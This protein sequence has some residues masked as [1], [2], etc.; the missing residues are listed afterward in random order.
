LFVNSK[1]EFQ[2]TSGQC[3]DN[4]LVCDGAKDC[5]DGSDETVELC[6]KKRCQPYVFQCSYGACVDARF[7]CDGKDDCADGS[8]EQH[9]SCTK[10]RDTGSCKSSEFPCKSG[11]CID[12][13]LVC[14]GIKDCPDGSDETSEQCGKFRCS[15]LTFRCNYGACIDL[16]HRC[17]GRPHCADSSDE[18][19]IRC[20]T[21]NKPSCK[22]PE[23]PD[24]GKYKILN[25]KDGDT[26]PFCRQVP[27]T[28]AP[29]W[30]ILEYQCDEGYTMA[31]VFS[32]L[33][34]DGKWANSH[35]T[36]VPVSCKPLKSD[37]LNIECSYKQDN[38]SCKQP[39]APGTVAS[40]ACKVSYQLTFEPGYNT[41]ICQEDGKWDKP[42]FTCTQAAHCFWSD[43]YG[44]PQE[45][46]LFKVAA[47][48]YY[49]DWNVK[50]TEM[51]EREIKDIVIHENYKGRKLHFS[52]DIAI[53]K[54]N[55]S[56]ELTWA[57]LPVCIDWQ[58]EYERFQLTDGI[59]GTTVGW[60]ITQNN[61]PSNELV[62]AN[63]PFVNF[64]KC[65]ETIPETFQSYV[66]RDKFCAGY[67]NGT[68]VCPGDS[69]GG[70][71]FERDKKFYLRGIVSVGLEPEGSAKCF[72]D[73]YTAFT[74]VSDF[75]TW[76]E[77]NM[78]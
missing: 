39:M 49:R 31:G 1:S 26:T 11:K 73:Q 51:Q 53:L 66:T 22:L 71:A 40:L 60:G 64:Q 24:H 5:N 37:N 61:E 34:S 67:L 41:I 57:V 2:C 74:R 20:G 27:G 76:M 48:K 63:L 19:P 7:K 58:N 70:L 14:D 28:I 38:V 69:G 18:D 72:T 55:I 44:R 59:L 52:S 4:T 15:P 23:K 65:W 13:T 56:V 17:D 35:P 42:L 10:N 9:P 32:I 47:G 45:K 30:T 78:R 3:I 54:L 75:L 6:G 50:D 16:D 62:T 25:C 8:D 36:C 33:C 77:L 29:E 12:D 21:D 68:S 43:I 46:E